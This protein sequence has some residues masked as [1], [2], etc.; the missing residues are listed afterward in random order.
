MAIPSELHTLDSWEL[1]NQQLR[2]D[3]SDSDVTS[4]LREEENSAPE[5]PLPWRVADTW[6]CAAIL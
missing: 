1:E 5:R 2:E 6:L 3:V 4:F